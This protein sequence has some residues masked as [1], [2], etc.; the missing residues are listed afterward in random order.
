[1]NYRQALEIARQYHYGQYR[2]GSELPYITHSMAV[3]DA[4]EDEEY[5]VV[6]LLHD[7]LEDTKLTSYELIQDHGLDMNSVIALEALTRRKDQTYLD[8]IL[9]CKEF[10]ISRRVKI[11]DLRHNLSDLAHGGLRDKYIMALYILGLPYIAADQ[12]EVIQ[13]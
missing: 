10:D 9:R 11:E 5:K 12:C 4:F 2:K 1:M 6:A 3:A 13:Y 7:T 8:Y